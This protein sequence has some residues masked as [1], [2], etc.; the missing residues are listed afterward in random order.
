MKANVIK[1][2]NGIAYIPNLG[3]V[4]MPKRLYWICNQRRQGWLVDPLDNDRVWFPVNGNDDVAMKYKSAL[5][6]LSQLDRPLRDARI[7]QTREYGNKVR[8]TG[9]A[10]VRINEVRQ[11]RASGAEKV[12][13]Y[14]EVSGT[15]ILD[16]RRWVV[17]GTGALESLL[18]TAK[19]YRRG[20]VDLWHEQHEL[21]VE[22]C[23]TPLDDQAVKEIA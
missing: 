5:K 16:N 21:T 1:L 10:G 23:M 19:D 14:V 9:M 20:V 4:R 15:G 11:I 6:E 7:I 12:Y 18:E 3:A 13:T 17:E 22:D 8:L 2:N